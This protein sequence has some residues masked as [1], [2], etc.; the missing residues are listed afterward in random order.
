MIKKRNEKE[1]RGY[2]LTQRLEST[3]TKFQNDIT[4]NL[5]CV[6]GSLKQDLMLPVASHTVSK[7]FRLVPIPPKIGVPEPSQ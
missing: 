3:Q 6:S 2:K 4:S 5:T 1:D 7:I